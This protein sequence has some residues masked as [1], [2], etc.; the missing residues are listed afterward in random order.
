MGWQLSRA[1]STEGALHAESHLQSDVMEELSG[2]QFSRYSFNHQVC[3]V[4]GR[5][6][7]DLGNLINQKNI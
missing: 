2:T 6:Q 4:L 5:Y 1:A 7:H 3:W